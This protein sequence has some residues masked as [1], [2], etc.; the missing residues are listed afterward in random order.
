MKK[1]GLKLKKEKLI[2]L[3]LGICLLVSIIYITTSSYNTAQQNKI[4]SAF[5]QGATQG[6]NQ[7]L[8]DAVVK[9]YQETDTC[10]PV[11]IF[12]GEDSKSIIDVA[13]LQAS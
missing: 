1:E 13:C 6:Y 12:V 2:I 4:T 8:N 3:I 7:G 5:T 9:I 10:T 11:P